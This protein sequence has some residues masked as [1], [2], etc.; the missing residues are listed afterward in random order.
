MFPKFKAGLFAILLFMAC[1][2]QAAQKLSVASIFSEHAVLQ[3]KKAVPVW[4]EATPHAFITVTLGA[5]KAH[6]Q[7]DENGKWMLYLSSMQ[8]G[9]PYD[10]EVLSNNETIKVTDLYVGEVWLASGQSNMAFAMSFEKGTPYEKELQQADYPM[11]RFYQVPSETASLP[12]DDTNRKGWTIVSPQSINDLS[13]VGYFF[14]KEL[15][16]DKK[17]PV[18]IISASRGATSIE[19]WMSGE[20]LKTHENYVG[21]YQ[22]FNRDPA[23]WKGF[24]NQNRANEK[25][26]AEIIQTSLVGIKTGIHLPTFN[27]SSWKTALSPIDIS[28]LS[29]PGFW[30]VVWLRHSFSLPSVTLKENT[31]LKIKGDFVYQ[32]LRIWLNGKEL[33]KSPSGDFLVQSHHLKKNNVIAVRMGVHWGSARL[34]TKEN[35]LWLV[36]TDNT[37]VTPLTGTW[38]YHSTIEPEAPGNQTYYN[39]NTVLYN[40]QIAPLQPYAIR[41]ILW[42][43]G[44]SNASK[45]SRYQRLLP[46]LIEDWRVGFRQGYLPFLTVQLANYMEKTEE[47]KTSDWAALREAQTLSL[48][49]PATGL[50]VSIDIGEENDIHPKN[51]LDV[52]K[53]LYLQARKIAYGESIVASGPTYQSM[54]VTGDKIKITFEETT[55]ELTARKNPLTGFL[56][57]GADQKFYRAQATIEKDQVI[58]FSPSVKNPV[59]VR[60]AWENNPDAG[61]Y[62][63]Q[64]LPA[65]PF[66]TDTW[67]KT[68]TVQNISMKQT[69]ESGL[70]RTG[71][72]ISMKITMDGVPKDSITVK[73]VHHFSGEALFSKFKYTGDT[74]T[75]YEH[76]WATPSTVVVEATI[77]QETVSLGAIVDCHRFQPGTQRPADFDAYWQAEKRALQSLPMDIQSVPVNA[78][79]P[80][81]TLTNVEINCLGNRPVRGY[82]AKPSSAKPRSLPIVLFLHAAGV[83]GA[84]CRS[85]PSRALG[86]AQRGKGALCFD[87]NAHGMLNGQPDSY[88]ENLEEGELKNYATK[89][90]ESKEECYF[91]G[92][93]LRLMRTIDY[94]TTQPEW[95]G[96]RILVIGESQGGGQALA[97]AGLDPRVTAA[98]ATVPAMCDWGGAIANRKGGWPNPYMS[99]NDKK[100]MLNVLPYFDV[101]HLLVGCKATL[102]VEIGLIDYT[103][104]SSTIYAALNQAKGKKIIYNLPYKGHHLTQSAYQANYKATTDLPKNEFIKDYLK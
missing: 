34:E 47:P 100:R 66:R 48:R 54:E 29:L 44:E 65:I 38:S 10:M 89:G 74:L 62:N 3:Q 60:Y 52:G 19:A 11:I 94:L 1:S 92:M 72:K 57:A 56:I 40:A 53:R 36:K 14:A 12:V 96:K 46:M 5:N 31:P 69:H 90:V 64:G 101:A 49:Y 41:G 83:K 25:R 103:C 30:G 73:V 39:T 51:K 61:L 26:R 22:S 67:S 84:W 2:I 93:Y 4:G 87:L 91:R 104:P 55:N 8:A 9:G 17:V 7:T 15:Y 63:K 43:Q 81:F 77:D 21:W 45:A 32:A 16:T 13:A 76:T 98:I 24:V 58:V 35:L 70:Y 42:Y 37:P 80:G 33:E 95:D 102:V 23:Y 59:A 71:E 97:A 6:C 18:G 82:Y 99:K 85:E 79:S 88:Y 27:D 78:S 50:A 68:P 86:Y 20:M 28:S 75:I